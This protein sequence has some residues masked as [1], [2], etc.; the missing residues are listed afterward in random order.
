MVLEDS[1]IDSEVQLQII[2][3]GPT[4]SLIS[5]NLSENIHLLS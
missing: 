1:A 4:L 3:S 5:Y 2:K